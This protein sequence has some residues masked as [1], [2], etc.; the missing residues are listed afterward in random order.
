MTYTPTIHDWHSAVAPI[1]QIVRA[2]GAARDGGMT[3]GGAS[4]SSPEPGGRSELVLNFAP[5]AAEAA[6]LAASWIVSRIMNGSVMRYRLQPTV[7]LVPAADLTVPEDGL[8]WDDGAP[9]ASDVNWQAD[10]WVPA[11]MFGAAGSV[12]VKADLSSLG[13]VL[14]FGHVIGFSIDGYDFAHVVMDIEY[15]GDDLAT[16]TVSPPLRRDIVPVAG[17]EPATRLRFRPAMLVV[18]TNA[19]EVMS[20]FQRGRHIALNAARFV[21]ALV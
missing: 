6:N 1:D 10:P 20:T 2:G 5:F 19:A 17:G 12:T 3:I 18:C 8:P 9:W 11:A 15:D 21:E 16:I 14:N 4:I 13:R 7:Q